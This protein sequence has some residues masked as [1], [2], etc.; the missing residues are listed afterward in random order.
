MHIRSTILFPI[1]LLLWYLSFFVITWFTDISSL[2]IQ[3]LFWNSTVYVVGILIAI[4]VIFSSLK[5]I[6]FSKEWKYIVFCF[7]LIFFC[8]FNWMQVVLSQKM[9]ITK[10]IDS[11]NGAVIEST[12]KSDNIEIFVPFSS[13]SSEYKINISQFFTYFGQYLDGSMYQIHLDDS[14]IL[15]KE[16]NSIL[17]KNGEGIFLQWSDINYHTFFQNSFLSKLLINNKILTQSY[18]VNI[19]IQFLLFLCLISFAYISLFFI[20]YVIDIFFIRFSFILMWLFF[21]FFVFSQSTQGLLWLVIGTL[22]FLIV[23]TILINI[24]FLSISQN[25]KE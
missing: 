21:V 8:V 12:R 22:F 3:I 9:D 24:I 16:Q 10:V 5:I 13:I 2:F 14:I 4:S 19:Y 20:G 25:K 15:N 7:L 17:G 23:N 11:V 18:G 1:I 6:S